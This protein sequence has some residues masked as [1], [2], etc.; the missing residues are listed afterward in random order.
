MLFIE[1][2]YTM[3]LLFAAL[4]LITGCST[5]LQNTTVMITNLGGNSGG[6]GSIVAHSAQISKILTNAHVCEVVKNGG[7]V[8]SDTQSSYVIAYKIS[9]FHDLCLIYVAQDLH[10][11]ANLASK[12]P[13][14]YS[15]VIVSGHPRLIPTIMSYGHLA[16]KQVIQVMIGSRACTESEK[17]DPT[18]GIFCGLVGALP[19]IK[20]YESSAVSATIQAGSSGSAVY[21]ESGYIVAVVFAGQGDFGYGFVVPY[22]YVRNF[23]YQELNDIP[24]NLVNSLVG[25]TETSMSK[26]EFARKAEE[27]CNKHLPTTIRICSLIQSTADTNDLIYRKK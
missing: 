4:I 19:I 8:T 18:T 6:S 3:R 13:A 10:Y 16:G 15:K 23:L 14:V 20:S 27:V 21:N 24:L 11:S 2:I 17:N 12:P 7:L 26:H 25:I 9:K 5:S 1:E 22:E